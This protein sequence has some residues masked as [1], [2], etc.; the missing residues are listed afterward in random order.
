MPDPRLL[1]DAVC[2]AAKDPK[3]AEAAK[4]NDDGIMKRLVCL[5]CIGVLVGCRVFISSGGGGVSSGDGGGGDVP[6]DSGTAEGLWFGTTDDGRTIAG[7]VLDDGTYWF[8]YSVINDPSTV[9]GLGQGT[10]TS[11]NGS[12]SSSDAR[13]FNLEGLGINDGSISG[14]YAERASLDGTVTYPSIN[15]TVVFN[16]DYNPDYDLAPDL[17]ALA[18]NY[19]LLAAAVSG[20]DDVI[21]AITASG[22][23]SGVG[24]S[25]CTCTGTVSPRASGNVY[26]FSVTFDGLPCS[27]G[28]S[29]IAG[30][31]FYDAAN[32]V[33]YTAGLNSSR[34]D[35]FLALGAKSAS[36]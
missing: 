6:E 18:G 24:L 33:F 1:R 5:I 31:A 12:F 26:D 9:A 30:V 34:T 29:T 13:D 23:F 22:Q 27:N 8:L 14:N 11:S 17:G 25:G 32:N 28:T 16:T 21:L 20:Y 19:V 7:V 15:D 2:D 35:G 10:G 4:P 36:P 3:I